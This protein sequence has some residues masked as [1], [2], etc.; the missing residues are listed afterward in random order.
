[1]AARVRA[2]HVLRHV[3]ADGS[4]GANVL[5]AHGGRIASASLAALLVPREGAVQAPEAWRA[6]NAATL[7]LAALA[8]RWGCGGTEAAAGPLG[9]S[10]FLRD[11]RPLADAVIRHLSAALTLRRPP[12]ATATDYDPDESAADLPSPAADTQSSCEAAGAVAATAAEAASAADGD[13]LLP[14]LGILGALRLP[15]DGDSSSESEN[16]SGS[17]C[18]WGGEDG[19]VYWED[20]SLGCSGNDCVDGES[21][22]CARTML[23]LFGGGGVGDGGGGGPDGCLPPARPDQHQRGH[24]GRAA[25]VARLCSALAGSGSYLVREAAAAALVRVEPACGVGGGLLGRMVTALEALPEDPTMARQALPPQAVNWLGGGGGGDH[26]YGGRLHFA[27]E[28][29]AGL[30]AAAAQPRCSEYRDAKGTSSSAT[31]VA[32]EGW[33]RAAGLAAARIEQWAAADA[34]TATDVG[35]ISP[36]LQAPTRHHCHTSTQISGGRLC[37]C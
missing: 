4:C 32:A 11:R 2:L 27:L 10:E 30:V 16:G 26:D 5:R 8:A 19:S 15:R 21:D 34:A 1:M 7:T 12:A 25:V 6:K 18:S 36:M 17:E 37:Q 29:L 35:G 3:L 14:A 24:R 31:A 28:R 9:A 20:S 13:G 22:E 33:D 23:E